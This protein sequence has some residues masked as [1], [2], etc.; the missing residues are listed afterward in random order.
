MEEGALIKLE[1]KIF[2]FDRKNS[3]FKLHIFV[4][5]FFV[6][7]TSKTSQSLHIAE[8]IT[9]LKIV[10]KM[11]LAKSQKK[12]KRKQQ[13][14]IDR[15]TNRYIFHTFIYFPNND[16]QNDI[17]IKNNRNP[18]VFFIKYKVEGNP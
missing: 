9:F 6:T 11:L 1:K 2:V 17:S 5:F 14:E 18:E 13:N 10:C 12:Y 16:T 3:T 15:Q 8:I 4:W 7:P